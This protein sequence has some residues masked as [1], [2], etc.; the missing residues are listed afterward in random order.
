ML[1][2]TGLGEPTNLIGESDLMALGDTWQQQTFTFT[3]STTD[4]YYI[5]FRNQGSSGLILIYLLM[6]LAYLLKK[7]P[8][9]ALELTPMVTELQTI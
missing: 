6:V 2:N 5:G 8:L 4:L 3:P 1:Y 9:H 7:T